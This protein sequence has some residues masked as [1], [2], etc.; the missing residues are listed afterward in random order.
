MLDPSTT[1][2]T[3]YI[4]LTSL[5]EIWVSVGSMRA[6]LRFPLDLFVAS[7]LNASSLTPYN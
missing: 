4:V 5:D 7:Y 2:E 6:G 3:F 1:N